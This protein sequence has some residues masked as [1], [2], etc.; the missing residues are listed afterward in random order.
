MT[1]FYSDG[2]VTI[3]HGDARNLDLAGQVACTV[4]SPPYNAGISYDVH[5][6]V[7]PWDRYREM[8]DGVCAAIAR[9]TIDNG[10]RAW[11]NVTP[12]VPETPR[13]AGDHSGRGKAR[14]VSLL[15]L[16]TDALLVAG[17]DICDYIAWPSP[18]GPG[19]AWG[20]WKSPSGPNL[21]GE[22]EA[23]ILAHK[24]TF[25]RPTPPERK[26]WRDDAGE[27]IP[28]T[29]NVWKMTPENKRGDHP[30]PFPIELPARCI[31]LSSWPGELVFDPF[32]GKGST[33]IAAATLGRRAVGVDVSEAYCELA[34]RRYEAWKADR[35]SRLFND[36]DKVA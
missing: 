19:C 8:A 29:I 10:G 16:W 26:G 30:A 3:Y 35:D 20:S 5:D 22:W 21:R 18:R 23:I 14:R 24:G 6:D 31:R 9:S 33:L 27:W 12:V 17:L 13:P 1:P 36:D 7:M 32:V 11:I 15:G 25:S 28:L 4:T 2:D 34:A